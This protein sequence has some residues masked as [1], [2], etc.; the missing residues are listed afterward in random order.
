[1]TNMKLL[2]RDS[3][4]QI[5]HTMGCDWE[6]RNLWGH[7]RHY[8]ACKNWR[9]E[10]CYSGVTV[11][12]KTVE[13]RCVQRQGDWVGDYPQMRFLPWL[14]WK[15]TRGTSSTLVWPQNG[16]RMLAKN[17]KPSIESHG[18][19]GGMRA[20]QTRTSPKDLSAHESE[21]HGSGGEFGMVCCWWQGPT[22]SMEG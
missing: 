11:C 9:V 19:A 7:A 17:S 14:L 13:G 20:D 3:L 12:D 5:R 15:E 6:R 22:F 4:S 8:E 18:H 1:M 21:K 10:A 2:V 16:A